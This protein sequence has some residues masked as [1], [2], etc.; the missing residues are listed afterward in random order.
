MKHRRT[1]IF[2]VAFTTSARIDLRRAC[3]AARRPIFD[4]RFDTRFLPGWGR[5]Q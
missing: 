2:A 5:I 3:Q 1:R 4:T